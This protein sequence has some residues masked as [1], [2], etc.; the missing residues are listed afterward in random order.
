MRKLVFIK[1]YIKIMMCVVG[2]SALNINTSFAL[3]DSL[4]Y[5]VDSQRGND[6]N[7]GHSPDKAWKTIA[8]VNGSTFKPGNKILFKTGTSYTGQ[9]SL[10]GTG[11]KNYPIIVSSYG[12]GAKPQIIGN[13]TELSA[14]L[15]ANTEYCQIENLDISNK[16]PERQAKR[17]GVLVRISNF[18]TAHSIVLRN[19]DIHDVNGS[20]IKKLGGGAAILIHNEGNSVVSVFDGLLI[21]GCT[22]CR[23]ERN[24]I[25]FGG[26]WSRADWH[27]NR[28]VVIRKNIIEEIPGDGIVPIGCDGAII[29]HN[30]LRNFSRLLPLGEAAA[31]IWPWSCDNTLIQYNEVSGHKAPWDGQGF[32]ADWNCRNTIIQYNYSHDNEGGFLLVCNDGGAKPSS[33]V[34]N[35]GSVIRYNISVNDG[36]RKARTHAGIFSP[37]VHIAGPVK[38]TKF[39]NN[40]IYVMEEKTDSTDNSFLNFTNWGGWSDSTSFA[41][42]IFLSENQVKHVWGQSLNNVFDHNLYYGYQQNLP[43]D[44]KP[45][46]SDPGFVSQPPVDRAGMSKTKVFKLKR[47]SPCIG[48]GVLVDKDCRYDFWGKESFSGKMSIGVSF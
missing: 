5:Y 33:S 14:L 32:D 45:L 28:N 48:A 24:G 18:G 6:L 11:S 13:G 38:N 22:I 44:L 23:C 20:L 26:Y 43:E 10:S 15:L 41:N 12:R 47:R 36:V 7:N 2:A 3:M 31:G 29:E 34:G 4:V 1:G 9:F 40:T 39:Y 30:V 21:E 8:K 25:T 42:N 16:G 17:V 19:L 35:I 27:P 37:V 46:Y